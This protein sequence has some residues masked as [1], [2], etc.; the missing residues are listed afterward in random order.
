MR[1]GVS[2][3]VVVRSRGETNL[4]RADALEETSRE[5][6]SA[7]RNLARDALLDALS[8]QGDVAEKVGEGRTSKTT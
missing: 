3:A 4:V 5:Q 2:K 6:V 8:Q 1:R 7:H